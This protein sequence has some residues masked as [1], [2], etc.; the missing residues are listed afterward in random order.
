MNQS[1]AAFLSSGHT[2]P[3]CRWKVSKKEEKQAFLLDAMACAHDC[4]SD[5]QTRSQS[6]GVTL[7]HG[8]T[9]EQRRKEIM[10]PKNISVSFSEELE[11]MFSFLSNL[12]VMT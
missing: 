8:Q 6:F 4:S 3:W 1:L 12:A 9:T 11:V 5:A 10:F 2:S 7:C